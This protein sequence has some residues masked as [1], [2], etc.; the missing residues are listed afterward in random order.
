MPDFTV[1]T[2]EELRAIIKTQK[3][4]RKT[5]TKALCSVYKIGWHYRVRG[6]WWPC[7]FCQST[8]AVHNC[9]WCCLYA[10]IF[11]GEIT[12]EN[13]AMFKD[14]LRWLN[15][16]KCDTMIT[17]KDGRQLAWVRIPMTCSKLRYNGKKRK[18]IC[19]DYE[20]RPQICRD[21]KCY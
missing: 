1:E 17:S 10:D 7:S 11:L 4:R 3:K 13:E 16:H 12:K 9:A 8:R 6:R 14:K 2:Q 21:Y 5:I 18:Y 19:N 20:N 15:L